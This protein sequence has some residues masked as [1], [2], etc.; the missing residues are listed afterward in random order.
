MNNLRRNAFPR[1]QQGVGLIETMIAA[2][3]LLVGVIAV[4]AL[5]AVAVA[6]SKAEGDYGTQVTTFGQDKLEQ[7]RSLP[8]FNDPGLCG[9]MAANV[10]CGGV[11]PANPQAGYVDYL[12]PTGVVVGGA[13]HA[14]FTRQ[15]QLDM[16]ATPRAPNN[17]V[18]Q[19]A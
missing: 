18:T 7:L 1:N 4:M 11:D 16:H 3:I 5:F 14:T 8:N 17:T 12:S 19:T 6:Q 10:T 13:A 2:V 15:W 9:A